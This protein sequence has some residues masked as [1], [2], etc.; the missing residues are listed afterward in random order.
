[1]ERLDLDGRIA[2]VTGA[3]RGIGRATALE[4]AC[5][6]AVLALHG[7]STESLADTVAAIRAAGGAVGSLHT[8]DLTTAAAASG[9]ADEVLARHGHLDILINNAGAL[10]LG[11]PAE[12]PPDELA[13][14]LAVNVV[15]PWALMRAM[16]PAMRTR[17]RGV[18]VNISSIRSRLPDRGFG[19]YCATKAGLLAVTQCLHHE[20]AGTGVRVVALSPGLTATGMA[21]AIH[22][23]SGPQAG[24]APADIPPPERPARVI[25]WLATDA[26]ADLAGADIILQFDA[27]TLRAGL[28]TGLAERAA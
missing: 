3:A 13:R 21:D 22:A 20:L 18:I 7:R 26:A 28:E 2:L 4:L 10:T 19:A 16:L 1:M 5:G 17:G 8:A 27:I 12:L 25:G 15:A 9:L 23:Y 6:G 24:T 11:S 14:L